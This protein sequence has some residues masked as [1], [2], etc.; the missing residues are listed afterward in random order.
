MAQV[1]VNLASTKSLVQPTV[2]SKRKEKKQANAFLPYLTLY[3]ILLSL[4]T[5]IFSYFNNLF[6]K[7]KN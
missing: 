2:L 3:P 4:F 6:G 1:V 7:N 5:L